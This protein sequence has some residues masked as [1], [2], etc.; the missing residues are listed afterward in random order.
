MSDYA[1]IEL[2][3]RTERN[4]SADLE[5]THFNQLLQM[6]RALTRVTGN[7]RTLL[8]SDGATQTQSVYEIDRSAGGAMVGGL[9]DTVG[10]LAD[11]D[12]LADVTCVDLAGVAAV[13]IPTNGLDQCVALV[14]VVVAGA[15]VERGV[16]GAAAATGTA[17]HPTPAQ[18]AEALQLF[19]EDNYNP[20][21]LGLVTCRITISRTDDTQVVT[22]T[23]SGT[24]A[25]GNVMDITINGELGT[26]TA[27]STV[28]NDEVGDLRTA[29]DTAL[30]AEA[31]TVG[32]AT[33]VITVTA[34]VAGDEFT[35]EA[36]VTQTG[37]GSLAVAEVLTTDF[38]AIAMTHLG[39]AS[40]DALKGE[41]LAG[42]LA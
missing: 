9:Y 16:F 17:E 6:A 39:A 27:D 2:M 1:N 34:D 20:S 11:K 26:H 18:I 5:R 42:A 7:D 4:R 19:G 38:A 36:L 40:N 21:P 32:G 13:A 41:R 22:Y 25:V 3:L 14:L 31:V 30:A 33:N 28:L 8:S 37:G 35:Y 23:F 24:P 12:L 15:L 29:L 10:A